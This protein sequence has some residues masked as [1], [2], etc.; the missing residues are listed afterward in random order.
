MAREK[1]MAI[2]KYLRGALVEFSSD[3]PIPIPNVIVFQ[4]NPETMTHTWTPAKT[5]SAPSSG[6]KQSPFAVDGSPGEAFSFTLIMDANDMITDGGPIE[7][8][9][10]QTTGIYSRLAALEMLLFP[11]A[12]P[13]AALVGAVSAAL[14]NPLSSGP[15][16]NQTVP[17]GSL[18]VALFIWGPGRIVPVHVTTLTITEKLYDSTL[19]N[20]THAEAQIGLEVVR[21]EEVSFVTG[22]LGSLAGIALG[23][24]Q[25]I[26]EALAIANL[27]NAVSDIIGMLPV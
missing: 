3:F 11:A 12:P 17:A 22:P 27:G 21:Q 23:Y 19:L 26:R 15:S 18:P 25:A 9:L 8:G 10:A 7:Q 14:S 24:T 6:A 20:P 1:A 5:E 16:P 2:G 4:Y 13:F